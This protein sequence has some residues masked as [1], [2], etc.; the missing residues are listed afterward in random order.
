[1]QFI[2]EYKS[3]LWILAA[4]SA[5]L[6]LLSLLLIPLILI[7]I[8]EDYFIRNKHKSDT[9]RTTKSPRKI[10]LKVLC[11]ILGWFL[12]LCGVAMLLLPGQGIL[13]ILISLTLIDFPYKRRLEYYLISRPMVIKNINKLRKKGRVAPLR[14]DGECK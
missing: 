1:M 13:T 14:L 11:N 3:F 9:E 2:N 7:R 6:F 5:I 12:L 10:L 8:P 4:L